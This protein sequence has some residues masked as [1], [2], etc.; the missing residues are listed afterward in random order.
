ML[1]MGIG[2]VKPSSGW[3]EVAHSTSGLPCNSVS[4]PRGMQTLPVE[5][6]VLGAKLGSAVSPC[7]L[8]TASCSRLFK[9]YFAVSRTGLLTFDIG[10]GGKEPALPGKHGEDGVWVLIQLSNRRYQFGEQ[11]PAERIER[12]GTIELDMVRA[13]GLCLN[14]WS[15]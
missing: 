13:L 11:I 10:A 12:L 9:Y 7:W 2:L 15:A 8:P 6:L 1:V 5:Q 14:A 3:M 4:L